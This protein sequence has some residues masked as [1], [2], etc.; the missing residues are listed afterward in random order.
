MTRTPEQQA[1]QGI[2]LPPPDIR[3]KIEKTA[4]YV[5]RNGVHF[6]NR[7]RESEKHNTKFSFLNPFDP[8]YKYYQWRLQQLR[9]GIAA[10][11]KEKKEVQEK[12]AIICYSHWINEL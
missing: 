12:R 7:I 2:I 10:P 4:A 8:Y 5:Q 3:D 11:E 6:E 9:A 1:P